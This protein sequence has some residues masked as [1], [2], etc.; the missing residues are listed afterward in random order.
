MKVIIGLLLTLS[1]ISVVFAESEPQQ[2]KS[3]ESVTSQNKTQPATEP[4]TPKESTTNIVD[5]CRT[6]TC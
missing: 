1:T 6:H 4:V 5:F 2:P 3:S